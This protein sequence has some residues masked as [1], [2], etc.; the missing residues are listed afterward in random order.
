MSDMP[1]ARISKALPD[2]GEPFG[3]CAICWPANRKWVVLRC[4]CV[5]SHPSLASHFAA[6]TELPIWSQIGIITLLIIFRSYGRRSPYAPRTTSRGRAGACHV[7][8]SPFG[9]YDLIDRDQKTSSLYY[10]SARIACVREGAYFNKK[11][12]LSRFRGGFIFLRSHFSLPPGNAV[13]NLQIRRGST[14]RD[15]QRYES[16]GCARPLLR[17]SPQQRR[18]HQ[19]G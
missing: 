4:Q 7:H 11:M 14:S 10:Y 17:W 2:L 3:Q 13:G 8:R 15:W 19:R 9:T 18:A 1:L 5:R 12:N 6:L 16:S